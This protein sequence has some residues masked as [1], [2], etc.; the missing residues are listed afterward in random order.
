MTSLVVVATAAFLVLIGL[1]LFLLAQGS[2][3]DGALWI[4]AAFIVVLIIFEVL[5]IVLAESSPRSNA[6]RAGATSAGAAGAGASASHASSY[7]APKA[8]TLR[9][10]DCAT[11]FDVQD[12]GQRPLYHSCPGC[13]AEGVLKDESGHAQTAPA[14]GAPAGASPGASR[15]ATAGRKRLKLRCGGCEHIFVLEDPGTRPLRHAC[16]N[17][18]RKGELK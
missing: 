4:L 16:P 2:W 9:C 3:L 6:A 7:E 15:P 5:V 18:G 14:G 17:C 13:G 12:Y 1:G 10:G 11:I 8:L